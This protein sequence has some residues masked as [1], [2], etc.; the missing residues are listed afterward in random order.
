MDVEAKMNFEMK[1]DISNGHKN[2]H[3][4]ISNGYKNGYKLKIGKL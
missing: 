3:K 4:S 1:K 2:G